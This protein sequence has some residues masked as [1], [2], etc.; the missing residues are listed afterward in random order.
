M[1]GGVDC[2]SDTNMAYIAGPMQ[3]EWASECNEVGVVLGKG[4]FS[5]FST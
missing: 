4:R 1:Y 3:K 5:S 2:L